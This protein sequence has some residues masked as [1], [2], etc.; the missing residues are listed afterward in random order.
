LNR[1]SQSNY[2]RGKNILLGGL[3]IQVVTFAFFII[4]AVHFDIT[5]A[6][7]GQHGGKWRWLM[8]SLYTASGLIL[9]I[10]LIVF[11]HKMNKISLLIESI[12]LSCY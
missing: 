2:D 8:K 6:K 7:S 5:V 11:D 9:V 1:N 4:I 3:V 10:Y 12:N